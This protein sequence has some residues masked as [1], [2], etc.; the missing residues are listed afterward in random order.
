MPLH[1]RH[2]ISLD[3]VGHIENFRVVQ[4]ADDAAHWNLVG[5]VTFKDIELD[6]ALKGFSYSITDRLVGEENPVAA[7]FVPYPYYNDRKLLS[8]LIQDQ[9]RVA[10][11]AWRKKQADPQT[12][13]LLISFA[14]FLG[15]PAYTNYWNST[16]SPLLK[17]LS[18]RIGIGNSVDFCQTLTGSR[19][20]TYAAYF[21]PT[22]E[23][24]PDQLTLSL[25][26]DALERISEFIKN[27]EMARSRGVY[28]ARLAYIDSRYELITVQ[29]LDGSVV[30]HSASTAG[31]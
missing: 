16:L 20:E 18:S 17:K 11:G 26:S 28:L 30:N 10:A 19:G 24:S 13:S 25:V 7:V 1:Q 15:A 5:D 23:N 21:M 8:E 6:E 4:D 14:L 3:T 31:S 9:E 27:D 12:V 22:R 29:Y 2:D